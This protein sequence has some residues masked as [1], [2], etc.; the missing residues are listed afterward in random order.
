MRKKW[1][2]LQENLQQNKLKPDINTTEWLLNQICR[3]NN[4]DEYP[5][6]TSIAKIA[7]ITPAS[8]VWP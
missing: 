5:I 4:I 7:F 3:A 2:Q 8:N 6:I 1:F